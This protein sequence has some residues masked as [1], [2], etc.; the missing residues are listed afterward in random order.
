MELEG[1]KVTCSR[2]PIAVRGASSDTPL[3]MAAEI[4]LYF[5]D[6]TVPGYV[7]DAVAMQSVATVLSGRYGMREVHPVST[8]QTKQSSYAAA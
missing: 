8:V 4:W 6:D 3:H 1:Q 2:Q 5:D 7:E